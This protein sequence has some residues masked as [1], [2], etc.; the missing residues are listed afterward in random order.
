M[1]AATESEFR[2]QTTGWTERGQFLRCV[3]LVG[4][5]ECRSRLSHIFITIP[6][7]MEDGTVP[8]VCKRKQRGTM[9]IL[10]VREVV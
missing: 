9:T 2:E 7:G 6:Q 8:A 1:T 5:K 4:G 10:H 3:L